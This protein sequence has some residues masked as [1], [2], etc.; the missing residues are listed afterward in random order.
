MT[1][2]TTRNLLR[3]VTLLRT[4]DPEMTLSRLH[5]FLLIAGK[6]D[7]LVRD[8][9]R[10][11]G[12]NQATI[13]RSIAMLSDKPQRGNREGLNWVAATPDPDDPRRVFVNLTPTG[14][15]VLA[16]LGNIL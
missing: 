8:L 4:L 2:D 5:V 12:L 6:K 3:A 10:A 13:S 7:T 14:T 1:T 16:D 11:T 15:K 9:S